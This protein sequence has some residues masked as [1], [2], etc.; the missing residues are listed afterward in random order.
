MVASEKQTKR[1]TEW[2]RL[3]A[4]GTPKTLNPWVILVTVKDFRLR[5]VLPG[6]L[7]A[8]SLTWLLV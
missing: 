6:C 4:I 8:L 5:A 3:L 7:L 1:R 2:A